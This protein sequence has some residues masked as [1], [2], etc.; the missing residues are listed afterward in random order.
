M[1]VVMDLTA[2]S[3]PVFAVLKAVFDFLKL[4][5]SC[6]RVLFSDFC[7]RDGTLR[8]VIGILRRL[9]GGGGEVDS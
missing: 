1:A 3:R 8:L 5:L 2:L 6:L 7:P 9:S 4:L